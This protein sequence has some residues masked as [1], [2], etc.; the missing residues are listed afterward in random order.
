MIQ[1]P[2]PEGLALFIEVV[3]GGGAAFMLWR[4]TVAVRRGSIW[5]R[6][7]RVTRHDQ[8]AWFWAYVATYLVILGVTVFAVGQVILR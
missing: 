5:L 1:H 7:E 3:C 8:P 6:G 4:M 2:M